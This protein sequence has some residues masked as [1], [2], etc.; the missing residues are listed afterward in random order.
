MNNKQ[1]ENLYFSPPVHEP[2]DKARL[3][4]MMGEFRKGFRFLKR[5]KKERVV[6]IFGSHLDKEGDHEYE[7]ARKLAQLLAKEGITVLTG[8][9]PGIME[10][11]NRGALEAG[12]RSVGINLKF[13][14][15]EEKN[16]YIKESVGFYY[17]FVRRVMLAHAAQG[18]VFFPGGFGTLDE[19]FEISTLVS[20]KKLHYEIPVVLVGKDYWSSLKSWIEKVPIKKYQTLSKQGLSFWK[21]A[22]SPKEAIELLKNIAPHYPRHESV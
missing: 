15:G 5:L 14:S 22:D 8:G 12:G 4:R 19:F 7:Q 16:K 11:A 2:G 6:S 3:D 9:G 1:E 17:L 10:A 13:L 20:T 18:Y 21:I